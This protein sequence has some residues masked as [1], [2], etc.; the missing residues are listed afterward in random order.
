VAYRPVE[1]STTAEPP[2][3]LDVHAASIVPALA[4]EVAVTFIGTENGSPLPS[5]IRATPSQPVSTS[6]ASD[7]PANG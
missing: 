7:T 2:G 4:F 5:G 3:R 1:N 6:V